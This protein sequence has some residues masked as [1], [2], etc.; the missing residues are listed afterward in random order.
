MRFLIF[1]RFL[2]S[3]VFRFLFLFSS[4]HF[5]SLSASVKISK[6]Q[7]IYF[8]SENWKNTIKNGRRRAQ[9]TKLAFSLQPY[10]HQLHQGVGLVVHDAGTYCMSM[11]STYNLKMHPSE[12]WV[13]LSLLV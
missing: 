3:C 11:A 12:Y 8:I 2:P 6:K 10:K 13:S 4:L 1:F 9:H 5:T 7:P